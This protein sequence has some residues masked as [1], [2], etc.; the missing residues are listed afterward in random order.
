MLVQHADLHFNCEPHWITRHVHVVPPAVAQLPVHFIALIAMQEVLGNAFRP[1]D[2]ADGIRYKSYQRQQP[3][4]GLCHE[5]VHAVPLDPIVH[6]GGHLEQRYD[7]HATL[8][9]NTTGRS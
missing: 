4:Q 5:A 3:H 1:D 2:K 7:R 8:W 9:S 6:D